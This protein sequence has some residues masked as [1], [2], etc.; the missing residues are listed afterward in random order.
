MEA[1]FWRTA[2]FELKYSKQKTSLMSPQRKIAYQP[3]VLDRVDKRRTRAARSVGTSGELPSGPIFL[4]IPF[5]TSFQTLAA[6]FSSLGEPV[7]CAG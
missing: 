7:A 1:Q 5:R 3:V 2:C 4:Q 6:S